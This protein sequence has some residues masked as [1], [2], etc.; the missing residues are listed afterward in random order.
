VVEQRPFKPKVV[1]SIPTAPTKSPD[2]SIDLRSPN[3]SKPLLQSWVLDR[4][5]TEIHALVTASQLA[6]RW[7]RSQ[8]DSGDRNVLKIPHIPF[9]F[10]IISTAA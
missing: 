7:I 4:N 10:E 6:A 8:S 2:D 3:L 9:R 1:G 5:W